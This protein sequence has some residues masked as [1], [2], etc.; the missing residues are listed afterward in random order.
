MHVFSFLNFKES[1]VLLVQGLYTAYLF[2]LTSD[3][4]TRLTLR[5]NSSYF[6]FPNLHIDPPDLPQVVKSSGESAAAASLSSHYLS[7]PGRNSI[8][9]SELRDRG[10]SRVQLQKI[11]QSRPEAVFVYHRTAGIRGFTNWTFPEL[12][13]FPLT[14]IAQRH[15]YCRLVV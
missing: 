10:E 12:I 2:I 8:V 14:H 11:L 15:G 5:V 13:C 4:S 6:S 1:F 7:G 9:K 3:H